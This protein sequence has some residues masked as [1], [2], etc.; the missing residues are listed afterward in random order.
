MIVDFIPSLWH[1]NPM[2]VTLTD[3]QWLAIVSSIV[4]DNTTGMADTLADVDT[5]NG[6]TRYYLWVSWLDRNA[7]KYDGAD[8]VLNWPPQ[9]QTSEPFIAYSPFTQAF[10]EE[11]VAAQTSQYVY[12]LVTDDPAGQAG[13]KELSVFFS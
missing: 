13:W 11:Y 10:V 2:A 7:P 3:D 12:I 6:L 4:L 9:E 5:A 1:F 8:P